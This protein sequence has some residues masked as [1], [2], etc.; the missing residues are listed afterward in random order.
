MLKVNLQ[1]LP[2]GCERTVDI[3]PGVHSTYL[4]ILKVHLQHLPD[5]CERTVDISP[6]MN[7]TYPG[8]LL[9]AM[10]SPQLAEG[11]T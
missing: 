4:P 7:S 10:K 11:N 5:D 2:E 3:S 8:E 9:W 6:S 1:Y